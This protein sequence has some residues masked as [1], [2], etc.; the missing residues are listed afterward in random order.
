MTTFTGPQAV[1]IY[2]A[3]AI[4]SALK[5][6]ANTGMKVNRRYTPRR[7]MK[8]AESILGKKLKARDYL[9]AANELNEWAQKQA[10]VQ[11]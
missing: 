5:F 11:S 4:A 9:G 8:T 7:M 10:G 3:S 2:Q 6:Y 1:A